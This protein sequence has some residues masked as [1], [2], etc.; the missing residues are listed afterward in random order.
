[1][2]ESE[3]KRLKLIA[4]RLTLIGHDFSKLYSETVS[5]RMQIQNAIIMDNIAFGI[6]FAETASVSMLDIIHGQSVPNNEKAQ[7]RS[8]KKPK[9][10]RRPS[11]GNR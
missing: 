8:K 3:H 1:M 4:K 7:S 10:Q 2:K 6:M 11:L 5:K 9:V